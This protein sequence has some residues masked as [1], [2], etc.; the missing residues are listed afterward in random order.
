MMLDG[1]RPVNISSY[2]RKV[3]LARPGCGVDGRACDFIALPNPYS[4][5]WLLSRERLQ[6]CIE[7]PWWRCA[8]RSERSHNGLPGFPGGSDPH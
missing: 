2:D 3:T 8:A 5:M 6:H 7:T 1:R 4:S